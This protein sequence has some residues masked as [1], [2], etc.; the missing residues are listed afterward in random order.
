MEDVSRV[1]SGDAAAPSNPTQETRMKFGSGRNFPR[2]AGAALGLTLITG[3]E[4]A[5]TGTTPTQGSA[6]EAPPAAVA[7]PDTATLQL[8][9]DELDKR[10]QA[11]EAQKAPAPTAPPAAAALPTTP[12][13]QAD[14]NGFTIASRDRAYQV[15]L[16]GLLQ[17][18]GRAFLGDS[19]LTP[20]DT[21]IV[22]KVRPILSGTLLNLADFFFSP[23]FGNNSVILADAYL[24]V[25]PYPWLRLRFGKFKQP[26]GLERLQAD[27]D[28][29][30]IERSLD[31]NLTP[32]RELGVQLWGDI[33]GGIIRYEAGVYDGAADNV[34]T[35]DGDSNGPKTLGGRIFVQPFNTA[36]LR[37]LGRLGVGV[38]ASEGTELGS[39]T[40]TWLGTFKSAGQNTIFSYLTSTTDPTLNV[41]SSG[42]HKRINPQLYYFNGPVGILGEWVKEHQAVQQG[43]AFGAY[44]NSAGHITASFAFGGDVT[45]EGVKPTHPFDLAAGT[46]G[47]LELGFRYNWLNIDD[48]AFPTGA[49]P[50]KSVHKAKGFGV[51]LNWQLSRNLKFSANYEQTDFTGG[52]AKGAD[53]NTEKVLIGRFQAAF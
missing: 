52:A 17:F 39:A 23:D 35:P 24:D 20:L 12:T 41:F 33:F 21:L 22:R 10:T 14:E 30:F 44:N 48:A 47:A 3:A 36:S 6:P 34:I 40:N 37:W 31:Q 4:H 15:R 42:R 53:R 5:Q 45:Y 50:A 51:A 7:S 13:L 38:A 46:L 19:A 2:A 28:L 27:Q 1:A 11:L 49:D 26:Y 18:D 9:L 16:K 8:R 25:H 29:T 43:K 32:Q